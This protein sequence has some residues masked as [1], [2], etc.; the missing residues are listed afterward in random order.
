[1]DNTPGYSSESFLPFSQKL[2]DQTPIIQPGKEKRRHVNTPFYIPWKKKDDYSYGI[3]GLHEEIEDFYEVMRPTEFE[4]EVRLRVIE[5]ISS[6]VHALW[7]YAIVEVFGS[8]RTGLYLPSSDIDM[9]I[10]GEWKGLPLSTLSEEL[11]KNGILSSDITIIAN[12]TVPIVRLLHSPSRIRVDISFNVTNGVK[13]AHLIKSLMKKYPALPKLILVLKQF[14]IQRGLNEVYN[15]GMSSYCL[16]LLIVSQLQGYHKPKS[17]ESVNLGTLL[18]EFFEHYGINFNYE[19]VSIH[20]ANDQGNY[21]SKPRATGACLL[22]VEDPLLKG[23]DVARGTF[24]IHQL[25]RAFQNAFHT[26]HQLVTSSMLR[27]KA[28]DSFLSSIIT[29]DPE[30]LQQREWLTTNYSKILK[31][32][33]PVKVTKDSQ[34]P[35]ASISKNFKKKKR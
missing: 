24:L 5:H 28:M 1:M 12:A 23:N 22:S 29:I 31:S 4:V 7:P 35:D 10:I 27:E 11:T 2:K 17:L 14:L 9:V 19:K 34:A 13:A 16:T 15:G 20:F 8:F 32:L 21:Q 3:I 6:I 25:K 26:L 33:S 30:E 18:I